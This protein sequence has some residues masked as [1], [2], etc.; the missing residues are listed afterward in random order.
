MLC[1]EG[2]GRRAPIILVSLRSPRGT[3]C[4][5]KSITA[6][7]TAA[8]LSALF[9]DVGRVSGSKGHGLGSDGSLALAPYREA[10]NVCGQ[11]HLSKLVQPSLV[12]AG[13]GLGT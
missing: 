3:C 5:L 11:Q 6:H 10:C 12:Q 2:E 9:L 7:L 4:P 13:T 1:M 8:L